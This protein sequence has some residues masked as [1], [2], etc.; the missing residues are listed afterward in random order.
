MAGRL[1]DLS[2]RASD[3]V[4][5]AAAGRDAARAWLAATAPSANDHAAPFR[6]LVAFA[7]GEDV[8]EGEAL[9][10]RLARDAALARSVAA[11]LAER[12]A[13]AAPPAAAAS[14]GAI[15][16]RSDPAN[17]FSLRVRPSA[18]KPN[19][20]HVVIELRG[21]SPTRLFAFTADGVLDVAL[22]PIDGTAHLIINRGG[23]LYA[24]LTDPAV[25][26]KLV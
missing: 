26:L 8:R 3:A 14:S 18:A 15:L 19:E 4:I 24:A 23:A 5:E 20:A 12:G 13:Y 10:R 9:R 11:I 16:E 2:Q 7:R 25:E 6:A 22:A 1:Q 17:G 21:A